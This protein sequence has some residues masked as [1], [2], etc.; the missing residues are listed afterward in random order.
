MPASLRS[1]HMRVRSPKKTSW[2]ESSSSRHGVNKILACKA[3]WAMQTELWE[4]REE[5]KRLREGAKC[6]PVQGPEAIQLAEKDE[7]E[8]M[9]VDDE[10]DRRRKLEQWKREIVKHMRKLEEVTK[11]PQHVAEE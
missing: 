1:K 7:I 8:K 10:R 11:L 3:K 2:S 5:V 9:E 4:L 6:S